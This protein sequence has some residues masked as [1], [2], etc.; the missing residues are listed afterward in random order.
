MT[1]NIL[2]LSLTTTTE[3]RSAAVRCADFGNS[4]FLREFFH[5]APKKLKVKYTVVK[6]SYLST[7]MMLVQV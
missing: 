6:E 5:A 3:Q 7:R 2:L 1:L 4:I